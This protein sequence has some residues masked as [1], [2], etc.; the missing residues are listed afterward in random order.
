[1]TMTE[2]AKTA[3]AT[4]LTSTYTYIGLGVGGDSTN[5]NTNELDAP[6]GSRVAI[7]PVIS[8]LSSIDYKMTFS[9]S[10]YTGLTLKEAGIF[11]ASSGGT[12]LTRVNFAGIGP[13]SASESFEIIITV[14][15]E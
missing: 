8:G 12:M 6:A 4:Y 15:V 1:M 14:E 9:G 3:A 10:S 7:T 13:I 2:G 5:P 11:S